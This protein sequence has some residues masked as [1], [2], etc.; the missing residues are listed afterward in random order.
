MGIPTTVFVS[1]RSIPLAQPAPSR[2]PRSCSLR[3]LGSAHA[4][5]GERATAPLR[6]RSTSPVPWMIRD[7]YSSENEN[8]DRGRRVALPAGRGGIEDGHLTLIVHKQ[9]MIK[10]SAGKRRYLLAICGALGIFAPSAR[11][12]PSRFSWPTRKLPVTT[13]FRGS[14]TCR[15]DG[16]PAAQPS[17]Q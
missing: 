8:Y 9:M 17:D 3:S 10:G 11:S 6:R 16:C 12:V 1:N 2:A 14:V 4:R 15:W 7:K 5:S 13:D